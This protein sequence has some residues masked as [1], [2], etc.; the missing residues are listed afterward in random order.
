VIITLRANL[1]LGV[2]QCV[3]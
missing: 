1:D 2:R 3:F